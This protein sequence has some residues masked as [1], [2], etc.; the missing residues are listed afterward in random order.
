[1]KRCRDEL[2]EIVDENG[3][4]ETN[5]SNA[6]NIQSDIIMIDNY[7]NDIIR[8]EKEEDRLIKKIS[9]SGS[10]RNL[11]EAITEQSSLKN[12]INSICNVL[13]KNQ[14]ELN[15]YNETLNSIQTEQNQITTDELNIK[16]KIQAKSG[17]LDKL[18][19]LQNLET[20][21]NMELNN[22]REAIVPIH[23]K[24]INYINNYEQTKEQQNK[25]IENDRKEVFIMLHINHF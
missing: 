21:L 22:S 1:M 7:I 16:S 3:K 6:K 8:Y 10:I 23:E 4:L 9:T 15:E 5:E 17:L 25:Q 19:H 14:Y 24:L 18:N 11:Q 12:C 13:E 2:T 20:I